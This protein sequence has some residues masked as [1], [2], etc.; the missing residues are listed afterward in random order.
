MK[1][2]IRVRNTSGGP[3]ARAGAVFPVGESVQEI[4]DFHIASLRNTR[5]LEIIT[6]DQIYRPA[7]APEPEPVKEEPESKEPQESK[8]ERV[9]QENPFKKGRKKNREDE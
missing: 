5:G 2:K 8:E 9:E 7:P 1:T 4:D 3:L 6:D